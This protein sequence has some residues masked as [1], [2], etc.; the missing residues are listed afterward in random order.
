MLYTISKLKQLVDLNGEYSDF[1]TTFTVTPND[2]TLE[3][4]SAVV[5][6]TDID[7]GA[8]IQ[9]RRVKGP[10][11]GT[12]QNDNGVY[13]NYFL[14]IRSDAEQQVD[15][16]V[17]LTPIEREPPPPPPP[18]QQINQQQIEQHVVEDEVSQRNWTNIK[19]VAIFLVLLGGGFLLYYF[20]KKDNK[21]ET[22]IDPRPPRMESSP[23]RS[24]SPTYVPPETEIA[25]SPVTNRAPFSFSQRIF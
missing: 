12:I 19:Y 20:Y 2:N 7:S 4:E 6:Q 10:L 3:Y 11:S 23:A 22:I 24:P 8:E 17:Q 9:Y 14:C 5:N 21:G 15:I 25:P 18:P 16:D 13:Q 1:S